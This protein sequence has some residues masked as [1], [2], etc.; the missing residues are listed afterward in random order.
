MT[1]PSRSQ[2]LAAALEAAV[3]RYRTR[4]AR[5]EAQWR[6]ATSVL[7]GG[8]TR[9]VLF[10]EP[11]P[12]TMVR[13]QG[14]R[15][16]DVDGHEYLDALGEFSAGLYGHSD[17]AIRAAIDEALDG[18]L[19]LSAHTAR[20]A[21]LALEIQRRFASLQRLRFTNSGTE[22][23]LLAIAAALAHTGRR[24]VMVFDGAYH[25]GVLSFANGGS[26]VNVPHEFVVARYNDLDD[27]RSMARSH[28]GSLAAVLVEPMLGAGGCIPGDPAFLQG[29]RDLCDECGAALIFDEVMT[30]RLSAGGR[31][32][33]LG[34][35]PDLT[36]IGKYFG[37]GLSFG[38]FGGRAEIMERFDP[39]RPGA[40]PHAGT[41][42]NNVLSMA[43]GLAGLRHVLTPQALDALNRR[44]DT[45]RDG[46]NGVLARN[47]VDAQVT[48]IGSLLSLHMTSRP[49]SSP[50]D[51]HGVEA[52]AK[53]LVFFDLLERGIFLAKRGYM[54]LSVPFD[55]AA[56]EAMLRAFEGVIEARRQ[57]L[58][59]RSE[60]AD[61]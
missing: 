33:L 53:A 23:N 49:V 21:A 44:G 25:G 22:A 31:Q 46:M 30:S 32:A 54:A 41:F 17:P 37:G 51:L 47:G 3:G 34:I 12:L 52:D 27:A 59:A 2:P 55:E 4:N 57:V 58:P 40:L 45:L 38:A 9:S 1:M 42:N 43:A 29:L 10:F 7:P 61:G 6:E 39:R 18:G 14:C 26:P 20:E 8:N 16:W 50:A 15:L 35:A 28:D 11:F 5:S 13:G 60:A 24:K 19:S 36:T 48:G 56:C